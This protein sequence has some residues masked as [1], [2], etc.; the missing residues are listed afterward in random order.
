MQV[1]RLRID[2]EDVATRAPRQPYAIAQ[3]LPE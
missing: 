3:G 2:V 1:D